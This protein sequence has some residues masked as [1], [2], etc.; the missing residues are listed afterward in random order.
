MPMAPRVVA[1]R[2]RRTGKGGPG[3]ATMR[4]Q[5]YLAR[6]GVASRRR[7]EEIILAGRV[8]VNG[9]VVREL[10][11][12]VR[13]DVDVVE[14]DGR[15]VTQEAPRWIAL[16]KP[17][18]YLSTRDDPGGRRTVY[19][20]LPPAFGTLFYVGR[21]D[22]TSEG[23]MLLTNQGGVAYRLT[24]PRFGV[25]RVYEV[26]VA[27]SVSEETIQR[28]RDGVV[29]E[30]GLARPRRVELRGR[31]GGGRS[32]LRITMR[33]GRKREVRRLLDA[34]GHDVLRLVR[35]RY[36]PILLG[37]LAPGEWRE[38]APGEV[39]KLVSVGRRSPREERDGT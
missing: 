27:G 7:S 21:L 33:E 1:E 20:L 37:D 25:D 24:H 32:R 23:L 31:P 34:V 10:G 14:V 16:N 38:L 11:T 18:G 3:G 36:G 17:V 6:S 8:S 26:E 2:E 39:R 19:D 35:V 5:R 4:L 12:Q 9:E 22:L 28:L 29:L 13:A 15:P 30:D